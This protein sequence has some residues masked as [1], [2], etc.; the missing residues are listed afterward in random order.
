M[1][2]QLCDLINHLSAR[3]DP[4]VSRARGRLASLSPLAT[5]SL[6]YASP[7]VRVHCSRVSRFIF[8]SHP[9]G[10]PSKTEQDAASVCRGVGP[11]ASV[12]HGCPSDIANTS[13]KVPHEQMTKPLML[14]TRM[15]TPH[16]DSTPCTEHGCT[17]T[18]TACAPAAQCEG[19]SIPTGSSLRIS[20]HAHANCAGQRYSADGEFGLSPG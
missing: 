4:A 2:D 15:L 19:F 12:A 1:V 16:C 13:C 8:N 18:T 14:A 7:R 10:V 20:R 17:G 9:A 11:C 3:H 5:A 6:P